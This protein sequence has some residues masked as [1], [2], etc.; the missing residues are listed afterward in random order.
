VFS[1]KPL[2]RILAIDYGEKWIGLAVSD[3]LQLT[4]Q[5]LGTHLLGSEEENR[6]FFAD[7]LKTYEVSLIVIGWPLKMNG[8]PG[9]QANLVQKFAQWLKTNF[10]LPVVLWD[11]RL[12]TRQAQAL[13]QEQ[14]IKANKGKKIEHTLVAVLILEAFLE[15]KKLD[16][17]A[18]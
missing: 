9:N 5:P 2:T 17:S 11:E 14:K 12:T 4:A 10:G 8:Q 6:L 3:P 18:P 13:L 16:E 15:R 1:S 7:L